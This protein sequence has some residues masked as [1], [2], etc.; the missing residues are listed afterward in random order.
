MAGVKDVAAYAG[1]SL[2]TVSNVLNRP[3]RVSP[4]T[5][6]KV[7]RA[8]A[9]LGFSVH[10]DHHGQGLAREAAEAMLR[11]AFEDYGLHRVIGRCHAANDASSGLM[12]R[13]G[14]RQEAHF[15]R[16]EMIKGE[17]TDELVFAILRD[18][19]EA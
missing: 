16:N 8:M 18:E 9:E 6:R 4:A 3:E 1:V 15:V 5:R 10:P 12:R 7:E 19:W 11:V 14:M 13:L 2:G 17:W